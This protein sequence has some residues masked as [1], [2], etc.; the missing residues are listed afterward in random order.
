MAFR[1]RK[2]F[3]TFEKRAPGLNGDSSRDLY[4]AGAAL[5]H[6]SCQANWE[7]VVMR[8]NDKSVDEDHNCG[9]R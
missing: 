8:V 9:L 3:G 2:V 4:D 6:L 1:T 5:Y 7:L